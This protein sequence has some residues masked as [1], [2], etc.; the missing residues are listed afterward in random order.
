MSNAGAAIWA[1]REISTTMAKDS[2][3]VV[4]RGDAGEAKQQDFSS[5]NKECW[6]ATKPFTMGMAKLIEE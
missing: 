5:K 6:V 4:R 1:C 3:F 2:S